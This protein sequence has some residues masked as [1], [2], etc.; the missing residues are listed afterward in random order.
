PT[1]SDTLASRMGEPT[2]EIAALLYPKQGRWTEEEFFEIRDRSDRRIEFVRG[3]LDVHGMADWVHGLL[4][5]WLVT[6]LD[7]DAEDAGGGPAMF[8]SLTVQLV[9]GELNR[10]PD[11]FLL[12]PGVRRA[13]RRYP[14]ANDVLI[15]FEV[16]SEDRQSVA[17]DHIEKRAEYAAAGIPEYWIVDPTDPADPFVLVLALPDGTNEYVEHGAFRPGE[18]ATSPALPSLRCDVAALFAAAEN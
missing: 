5:R 9:P 14:A 4:C 15:A 13:G 2:W 7:Q 6:W 8:A 12:R 17:R 11:V 1:P 18:F 10:E 3:F 16:V